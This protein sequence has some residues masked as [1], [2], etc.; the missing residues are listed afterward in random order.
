MDQRKLYKTLD[1]IIKEAPKFDSDDQFLLYVIEQI[2]KTEEVQIIGGRL[3]KLNTIRDSY[4]LVEQIGEMGLIEENYE[5]KVEEYPNFKEVGVHRS[6]L[7]KETDVY[8]REKGIHLYSATGI[9]ERFRLRKD[10]SVYFLYQYII[11]FNAKTLDSVLLNTLN[12]IGTTLSSLLR[13]RQIESSVRENIEEMEKASEIQKNIL[14]D[15]EQSFG[16][17]EIFGISLP[18]KV[19]GGDFFDYLT[20]EDHDKIGVVIGDAASKGFSA[21]AQ[22]LYV[23]GALKMGA[24]YNIKMTS[25]ITKINHLIYDTFPFERFVT[26]CYCELLTDKKGLC[27]YINAGH[28]SPMFYNSSRDLIEVLETTGPVLGPSPSQ[29]YYTESINFDI[30]DILV[31]YT[32]GIVEANDEEFRFY[33]DERLKELICS[34]KDRT[35]KEI[36]ELIVEDVQKFSAKSKYSDDKTVVVIKRVK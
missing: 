21:A 7:E 24:E 17:Y 31:L 25:M 2:I 6:V 15:H 29:K 32:D 9:G 12:I 18:E 35:P 20:Y 10:S 4:I 22:A 16:N 5:L 27:Q 8:L 36:C 3:W 19:V 30:N 34:S 1:L 33:G 13:S 11:A 28:N 26:L 14:P 23:S